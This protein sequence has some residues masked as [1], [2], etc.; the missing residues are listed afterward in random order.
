MIKTIRGIL[1]KGKKEKAI[2]DLVNQCQGPGQYDEQLKGNTK[3][4]PKDYDLTDVKARKFT[5]FQR[6]DVADAKSTTAHHNL[7]L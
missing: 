2:Q 4:N 6:K 1:G 3:S 7:N 5:A